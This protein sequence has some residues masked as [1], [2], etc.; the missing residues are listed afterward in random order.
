VALPSAYGEGLPKILIEAAAVGRPLIATDIPG[1]R[2]I[3]RDGENGYLVPSGD[4]PALAGAI[5]R[6]VRDQGLCERF[7]RRSHELSVE[8]TDAVVNRATLEVY[9]DLLSTERRP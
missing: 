4:V 7:G 3:V 1:C 8:F 9:H 6:L 2:E 5:D